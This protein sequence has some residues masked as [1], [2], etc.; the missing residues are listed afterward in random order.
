MQMALIFYVSQSELT[1]KNVMSSL[2]LFFFSFSLSFLYFPWA[3]QTLHQPPAQCLV[4][5]LLVLSSHQI[6]CF[7]AFALVTPLC[8]R[9]LLSPS[10]FAYYFSLSFVLELTNR[11]HF[12]DAL[13]DIFFV[14]NG[15]PYLYEKMTGLLTSGEGYVILK[16]RQDYL[17]CSIF[18]RE[19]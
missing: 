13:T 4:V 11:S 2:H 18:M 9:T 14:G 16:M 7:C 8:T 3:Q 17:Q 1:E 12:N 19:W 5:C 10:Y 15:Y 6:D